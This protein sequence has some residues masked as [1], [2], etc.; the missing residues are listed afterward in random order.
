MDSS[1]NKRVRP[2]IFFIFILFQVYTINMKDKA[3]AYPHGNYV[4]HKGKHY[5]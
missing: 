2:L 3:N 4:K 5:E 1:T